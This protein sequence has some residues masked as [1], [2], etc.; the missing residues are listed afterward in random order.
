MTVS[1]LKLDSGSLT[2]LRNFFIKD[3]VDPSSTSFGKGD[4][5]A[6]NNWDG[7]TCVDNRERL[8]FGNGQSYGQLLIRQ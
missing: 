2:F 6:I 5:P 4:I 1:S 8:V 7:V 3:Y